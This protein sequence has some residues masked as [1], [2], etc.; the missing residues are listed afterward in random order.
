MYVHKHAYV[1]YDTCELPH[2]KNHCNTRHTGRETGLKATLYIHLPKLVLQ[3]GPVLAC[4][5][6]LCGYVLWCV[7]PGKMSRACVIA[8]AETM[9]VTT[10]LCAGHDVAGEAL[11][12]DPV[13]SLARSAYVSLAQN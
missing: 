10:F 7:V 11:S 5:W 2:N 6:A 8:C 12:R 9:A 3:L 13:P 1:P 4:P